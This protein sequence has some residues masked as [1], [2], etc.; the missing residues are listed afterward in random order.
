[1]KPKSKTQKKTEANIVRALNDVC[2]ASLETVEGFRWLTHQADYT[3]FPASLLVTC[4]FETELDGNTEA[5]QQV[6]KGRIQAALLAIGIRF[7]SV[8]QQVTFDSEQACER[9]DEGNW[10]QRLQRRQGRAVPRNRPLH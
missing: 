4:V 3:N 1:M 9:D 6:L 2:E 5:H 7:K 8:N 10:Q